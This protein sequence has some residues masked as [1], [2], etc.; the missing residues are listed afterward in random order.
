M[1]TENVKPAAAYKYIIPCSLNTQCRS[2]LRSEWEKAWS[3]SGHPVP[4]LFICQDGAD[5]QPLDPSDA[6]AIVEWV[7]DAIDKREEK[8]T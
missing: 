2:L 3:G 7:K 1:S 4:L 5:I 8:K 6:N